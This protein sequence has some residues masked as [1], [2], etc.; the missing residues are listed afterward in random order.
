V[1]NQ[2]KKIWIHRF[3][4]RLSIRLGLYFGIYQL[5]VW[6]LFWIDARI[7]TLAGTPADAAAVLGAILIPVANVGLALIFV[8]DAVKEAHRLVGPLYRF[9][10]T[11]QAVTA[12]GNVELV[13]LR[14]GDHL[15]EIRD[16][17]NALLRELE[18]RG[19]I[20]IASP[21]DGQPGAVAA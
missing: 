9:R 1:R 15:Q 4:T 7:A 19:A 8:L 5:A 13:R 17:L 16:D 21:A 12:G 6:L 18:K 14:D 10:R 2:R 11:I 20:T 3:Q